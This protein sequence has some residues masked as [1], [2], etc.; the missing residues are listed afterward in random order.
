[1]LEGPDLRIEILRQFAGIGD[2]QNEALLR[3]L[4]PEVLIDRTGQLVRD[5]DDPPVTFCQLLRLL[6]CES[7]NDRA[8]PVRVRNLTSLPPSADSGSFAAVAAASTWGHHGFNTGGCLDPH[9][10][11]SFVLRPRI[12]RPAVPRNRLFHRRTRWRRRNPV[13]HARASGRRSRL[14][15]PGSVRRQ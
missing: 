1:M 3:G 2:L 15:K 14:G 11:A 13:R 10:P 12:D 7:G 8:S 5:R 9:G 6:G 4:Q